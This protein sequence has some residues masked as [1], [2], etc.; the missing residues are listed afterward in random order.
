M[1]KIAGY[2]RGKPAAAAELVWLAVYEAEALRLKLV[3][4]HLDIFQIIGG[5]VLS[6][7][8]HTGGGAVDDGQVT[9]ALVRLAR[10]MGAAKWKRFVY[11]GFDVDH[12]HLV[13]KG[14]PA[15]AAAKAQV[16]EL[17]AN[18]DGLRGSAKD[19]GPRDG[20]KWPL[21]T[22]NQGIKWAASRLYEESAKKLAKPVVY[23]AT[24]D[25]L[26]GRSYPGVGPVLIRRPKGFKF[27]AYATYTAP[28]GT[29][30]VRTKYGTWYAAAH[31]AVVKPAKKPATPAKVVHHKGR[32]EL[33]AKIGRFM[34]WN[35]SVLN[36][37]G[38]AT[39]AKRRA[40]IARVVQN[41]APAVLFVQEAPAFAVKWLDGRLGALTQRVGAQA[42]YIFIHSTWTVHG[43]S[44]WTPKTR[45][46]GGKAKPVTFAKV[47]PPGGRTILLVNCHPQAGSKH[48]ALRADWS[49][50]VIAEA[51]HRATYGAGKRMP[52]VFGGDFQDGVFA[53]QARSQGR[54]YRR[55]VDIAH[56][57]INAD[58]KTFNKWSKVPADGYQMDQVITDL[59][60]EEHRVIWNGEA[61]D[62][63]RTS[64]T[65]HHPA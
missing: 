5:Y 13:L 4:F 48:A 43:W 62:H 41:N 63:N 51:E 12:G 8:T 6:G 38:A 58:M 65:L 57:T 53:R 24:A 50:E 3:R 40:P 18:G 37:V 21:R 29:K 15:S 28:D 35:L 22:W 54:P 36:T 31:L 34:Q 20:V 19:Y 39:W 2:V 27:R 25:K 32:P 42:R 60:V 47:Q 1:V 33:G 11:Q 14:A 30:H 64:A 26:A 46:K 59:A 17:D 56:T 10:N 61:A 7:G 52:I 16:R 45:L 44:T 55:S 49:E 9:N 23:Y